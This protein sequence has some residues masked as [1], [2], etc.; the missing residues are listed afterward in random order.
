MLSYSK[1]HHRYLAQSVFPLLCTDE[2][3]KAWKTKLLRAASQSW[4][5]W[6]GL[7]RQSH[8]SPKS[9]CL[10]SVPVWQVSQ[11]VYGQFSLLT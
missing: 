5:G 8:V 11:E 2:E 9:F 7:Q 10:L 3:T 6:V 4:N 1:Y